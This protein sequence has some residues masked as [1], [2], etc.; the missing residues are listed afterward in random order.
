MAGTAGVEE[1]VD[2]LRGRRVVALTGAGVSTESGIP[3]YR[4]PEAL[5]RTRRPIQGPEFVRSASL[6]RRYWARAMAGWERFRQASPGSAHLALARLEQSGALDGLIT[7]NVDRLHHAAGSRRVIEL[8]GALAETICLACGI[9][10]ARDPLQA[11]MRALNPSWLETS[12][13]MAP[14]GDAELPDALIETFIAPEC[15]ACDGVLKPN[16]VFFGHNVAKPIV[17]EAFALVDRAEA[18]LVAGTSLA[19]FSGYRF[20]RRAADRGIPIAIVNR[21]P[22]RGE[23]RATLKVEASTGATLGE[24]A[25]LLG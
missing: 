11:R 21:G 1:L 7:Q 20:L 12:A 24:L 16:V 15:V 17:E 6:R 10:E 5:T 23:E 13:A 19:V 14:D 2:S 18:L 9:I 3:D 22:V 8:H 25:R 4:S